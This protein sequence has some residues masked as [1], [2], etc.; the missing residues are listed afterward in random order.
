MHQLRYD[1]MQD[2][3]GR[4]AAAYE[5]TFRWIFD[6]DP[7]ENAR[8]TSFKAWLKSD[9][10]LYWITGKPGSGKST[11]MKYICSL[12]SDTDETGSGLQLQPRCYEFLKDWSADEKLIIATFYFWNSGIQLQM[13]KKG[14]FTTLLYQILEQCPELTPCASTTTL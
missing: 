13:T 10:R 3:E 7:R 8:W 4:I 6:D 12:N 14:M 5:S 2:R 9:D 1:G 11:L